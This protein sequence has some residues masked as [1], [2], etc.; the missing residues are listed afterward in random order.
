MFLLNHT[1]D[2][3]HTLST[4]IEEHSLAQYSS[5]FV[6]CF[7]SNTPS[8]TMIAV[9]STLLSLLPHVRIIGTT[10]AGT[11]QEGSILDEGISLS[12]SV[13]EHATV[14]TQ[15]YRDFDPA[16]LIEQIGKTMI[17]DT[18]TL[19]VVFAHAFRFDS[20][21]FLKLLNAKYP[22]IPVVGGNS[23]DDFRFEDSFLLSDES[24]DCDIVIAA[25]SSDS[26]HVSTH[27]LSNWEPIGKEMRV[28]KAIGNNVYEIDGHNIFDV[29]AHYLGDDVANNIVKH[30]V[31]FPFVY[32]DNGVSVARA[33][34]YADP[35]K[36]FISYA[37]ALTEGDGV[38][39]A[40]ANVE[41][42]VESNRTHICKTFSFKNEAIYL[43]SCAARRQKLGSFLSDE[44][45]YI[46]QVAPMSGFIT[47][48]E[49]FHDQAGCSTNLLNI[50][51]T[52][53]TLNESLP[54]QKLSFS[55]ISTNK[56][57]NEI[58]LK[59]LTTLVSRVSN[60]L[61]D[62]ISYLEQF[63]NVVD[64][65]SIF[66]IA[67]HRGIITEINQNFELIS[68]YQQ[69]ELIG[70]PHSIIRSDDMSKE[71]FKAMWKTIKTGKTW[72]G[73]VTNT[74]KDGSKYY[75]L[76]H[77]SPI[78]NVDGSFKEYIAIRNDVTE[79]EEYKQFLKHELDTTSQNFQDN[80]HYMEQYE[81]AINST[82]AI[83][84]TD[85]DNR[86][87]HANDTF[88]KLSG[89]TRNELIGRNCEEL[90]HLKH[91]LSESCKH[92]ATQLSHN[93]I[94]HKI[95]TNI[96]KDGTEYVVN[97]LFYPIRNR[98]GSI[99][100]HLQIMHDITEIIHLN[101]EIINTQKE[102]VMT[103]GAIGETRS[104]ETGMHVTRVAEYSYLL[105]T[106]Y[107]MN[108]EEANL[109]KQ[110]SPMHDIGKVGIPDDILNK[111]GKLT[112][113]EFEIMKTHAALGYEM[114][115]SSE[116]EILKT[117]AIV[118]YTHHEKWDGSGYPRGLQGDDIPIH[119]RITAIADVFDALGHDRVYKKAW[120][121]EQ[122]L[123]LFRQEKGKHFDPNLIDMFFDHLDIF[124]KI[125]KQY[126]DGEEIIK[127]ENDEATSG[128]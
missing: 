105:A 71:T 117:S 35:D 123:E 110:A 54:S 73:L 23:G 63:K 78:F 27:Y 88:C 18:T 112:T 119:G 68:G 127:G 2:D 44:I 22:H 69:D 99:I 3:P 21:A 95:M 6:Q 66:S 79:L 48:G 126:A 53:V 47:Y 20:T 70:S 24:N 8:E 125:Q 19:L 74:R 5:I 12:F 56:E 77:I 30:G 43:Y 7:A 118:A 62:K 114:L 45:N 59:A 89:Y 26:L 82:T 91:R 46:S 1:Y 51:T 52:F 93:D 124:L 106:L 9:K 31:E 76:T 109:L 40:Y 33:P 16:K 85:T 128:R 100:E 15:G 96:A 64:E 42:V 92:I 41:E 34:V 10:T 103:M 97:N 17:E 122:I 87:T 38:H 39:F 101:E 13:F 25:I 14:R 57:K 60:D 49:F 67:D 83:L 98:D 94:V 107:G 80:I 111:P 116:R 104:K 72:K 32:N 36:K 29:Y 4:F 84:K 55:N 65:S 28:T 121:L 58:T 90:R 11:I 113:H 108:E 75:V 86:I 37:G 102:V 81:E 61:N 50:T 120:P 115:K